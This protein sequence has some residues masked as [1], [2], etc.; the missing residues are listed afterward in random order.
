FFGKEA[1][2][3]TKGKFALARALLLQCD[4]PGPQS[5]VRDAWRYDSFSSDLENPVLDV[6]NDLITP[7]DHKARMDMRLYAAD[8]GGGL[9]AATRAAANAPVRAKARIAVISKAANAKALLDAVPPEA[10]RDAGYASSRV[11]FLRRADEASEAVAWILS[12]PADHGQT[13]DTDQW[14]IERRLVARKLLDIGD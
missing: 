11:Q 6:F 10:T 8:I 3:T 5:L 13:I 7:A 4:R 12:L 1:P 9:R 2:T 14:W